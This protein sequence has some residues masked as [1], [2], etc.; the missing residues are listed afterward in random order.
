MEKKFIITKAEIP[1]FFIKIGGIVWWNE[2][3]H[4]IYSEDHEQ[5]IPEGMMFKLGIDGERIE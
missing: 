4:R 2:T 1:C 5:W 3:E